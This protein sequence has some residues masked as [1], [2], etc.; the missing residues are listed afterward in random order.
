MLGSNLGRD[1]GFPGGFRDYPRSLQANGGI[2]FRLAHNRFLPNLLESVI[3]Q[4]SCHSELYIL[5]SNNAA[6][7]ATG[8][9][10]IYAVWN[11]LSLLLI[12]SAV[13]EVNCA[14]IKLSVVWIS[15]VN[16]K[17]ITIF[18]TLIFLGVYPLLGNDSV[19]CE[20]TRPRIERLLLDNG[21]VNTPP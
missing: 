15:F 2:I 20:P 9:E 16:T 8:K 21:S 6:K 18:I 19:T 7:W 10:T 11:T 4:S 5:D 14:T 3:H 17:L 13:G 12:I 1:M